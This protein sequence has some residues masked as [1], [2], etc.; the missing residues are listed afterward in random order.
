MESNKEFAVALTALSEM[1]GVK[2]NPYA[3]RLYDEAA[4]GIGYERCVAALRGFF[5]DNKFPSVNELLKKVSGEGDE[6][7]ESTVIAGKIWGAVARYGSTGAK[8]A[9]LFLGPVAWSAVE[10]FG[11]WSELC[12]AGVDERGTIIAQLRDIASTV[13]AKEESKKLMLPSAISHKLLK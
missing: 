2:L 3:I 13:R 10:Y 1:R 11:G 5:Q 8:Q 4:Q 7:G 9:Q 12:Q 6:R